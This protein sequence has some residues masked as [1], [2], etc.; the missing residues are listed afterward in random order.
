MKLPRLLLR[1]LAL[2]IGIFSWQCTLA[3]ATTTPKTLNAASCN[4]SDVQRALNQAHDGDTVAIPA[5]T[6]HWTTRVD[7]T[8]SGALTIIGAGKQTVVG[9]GDA[10]V[11]IDEVDRSKNDVSAL[12]IATMLG[13]PFR[14]SGITITDNGTSK[15][16]GGSIRITGY[17]QEVRVDHI[18]FNMSHLAMKF[19]DWVYGVVDHCL[20]DHQHNVINISHA[21]WDNQRFGDGSW[22]DTSHFGSNRFIFFEDNIFNGG[23]GRS[24]WHGSYANDCDTG[25]RFVFRHNTF[26]GSALMDHEMEIRKRGCRAFEIY[27]NTFNASPTS[28]LNFGTFLRVGTGL[29]W[30]NSYT[31]YV[32]V[33]TAVTD[34]AG[35]NNGNWGAP[36]LKWGFCGTK[37]GPSAWDG[38]T[39][40]TG[41]PCLDQIGRGAGELLANTFPAV[42]N[43]VSNKIAWPRQVQ[44]PVYLWNNTYNPPPANDKDHIW[45]DGSALTKENRDYYLELPNYDEPTAKFNGSAGVG[46]GPL[47]ARPANCTPLVAYWATD[48]STLYQC[49]AKNTWTVYYTPYIYPHPLQASSGSPPSPPAGV[50]VTG[51]H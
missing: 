38:N 46:Q 13:K 51:I 7:Y 16:S 23:A 40:A 6:C 20:A 45:S 37:F 10:T 18:H 49:S 41:Y 31:G 44:E 4:A 28:P 21:A 22:A 42:I 26:N 27:Q 32:K 9:G 15:S 30:G 34:R 14:L 33:V 29:I 24:D 12:S 8:A 17:S 35:T 47:P 1:V 48:T 19:S 5:G 43:T 25:G 3:S 2:V 11:I 36:P 50:K 39:D